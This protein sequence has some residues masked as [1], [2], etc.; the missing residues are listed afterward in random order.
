MPFHFHSV[1]A[2]AR[3]ERPS[4]TFPSAIVQDQVRAGISFFVG[5]S[6]AA[7]SPADP[8]LWGEEGLSEA[9]EGGKV[10]R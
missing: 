10:G 8:P 2:P 6:M 9:E 7:F 3:E 4:R 5:L 1:T